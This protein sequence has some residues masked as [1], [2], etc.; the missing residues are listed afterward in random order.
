MPGVRVRSPRDL[1]FALFLVAVGLVGLVQ[2]RGLEM[3]EALRMG[4]GY[5]PTVL[6]ALLLGFGLVIGASS[7][8]IEGPPLGRWAWWPMTVVLGAI[9]LFGLVVER[10][11]LAL[12]T[13]ALVV[14]SSL[15]APERRWG[16][17]LLFAV[18]LAAGCVVVFHTLLGLPLR[19]WPF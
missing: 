7:L 1:L 5:F 14:V 19:V 8:V 11:G 16:E 4:P 15:A 13:A 3:G 2:A 18:L 12:T 9:V 10:L 17:V 6:S